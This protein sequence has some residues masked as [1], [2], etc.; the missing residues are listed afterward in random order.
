MKLIIK[1][2]LSFVI[3]LIDLILR[4]LDLLI[5]QHFPTIT[6]AVGLVLNF[7]NW[8]KDFVLWV[9]SW[10]PFTPTFWSFF[11]SVLIFSITLPTLIDMIKL[12]V[13]WWHAIVP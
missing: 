1:V 10:L 11:I 9:L 4:P 13:K 6:G 8:L 5:Y 7:L 3:S 12:V 2:I